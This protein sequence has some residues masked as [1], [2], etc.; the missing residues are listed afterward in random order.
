MCTFG[1]TITRELS[2]KKEKYHHKS[3]MMAHEEHNK[4]YIFFS[5]GSTPVAT[6]NTR[7]KGHILHKRNKSCVVPSITNNIL[8]PCLRKRRELRGSTEHLQPLHKSCL[9]E[10]RDLTFD[11]NVVSAWR[12]SLEDEYR[13][14]VRLRVK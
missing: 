10:H 13:S 12:S 11:L 2:K 4:Y 1:S 14:H 5:F 7:L 8:T 3:R 9:L 6:Q